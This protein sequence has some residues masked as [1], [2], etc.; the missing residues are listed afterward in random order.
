[1]MAKAEQAE[2]KQ[3]REEGSDSGSFHVRIEGGSEVHIYDAE[4]LDLNVENPRDEPQTASS[5]NHGKAKWAW[6]R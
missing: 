1:M 5:R 3:D 6:L 4:R 2:R